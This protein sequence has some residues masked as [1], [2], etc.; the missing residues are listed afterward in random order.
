MCTMHAF[1]LRPN[2]DLKVAL[3]SFVLDRQI[4][5]ACVVTCVGSLR[6]AVLR[7]ADQGVAT[8]I[9]GK[10][11]IVSLTG[12]LSAHGS[13]YHI[14]ISDSEGRT[15]GGHLLEGCLIYTTAEIVLA[16]LPGLRFL[17]EHDSESGYD[18]LAVR[19][20]G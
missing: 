4:E 16:E 14:S 8:E 13:H 18:E 2:Q 9:E 19:S 6:K 12:T 3:D 11:E 10:F 20:D 5:A 1:R 15:L 17:R 7:F